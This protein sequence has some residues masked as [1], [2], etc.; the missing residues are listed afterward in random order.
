MHLRHDA[1]AAA[2]EWITVVEALARKADGLVATVGRVSVDPNAGNVV[3]GLVQVSLDVRHS[4]DEARSSVV[5][6]LVTRASTIA[7]SRGLT[8]ER[9]DR[10]DQP[11]VPMDERLTSFLTDAMEAAGFPVKTMPSGA[12]HDAMVMAARVPTAMLFLRSLAGISHHPA[13]SVL[14]EDV[15]AALKVSREFLLRFASDVR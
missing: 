10:L 3:P 7:T 5:E 9:I 13:E 12:G 6:E 1:L 15:E 2:A 11:A 8:L 4:H 14:E